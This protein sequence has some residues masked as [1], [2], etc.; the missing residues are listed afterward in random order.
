L[1][2]SV[3]VAHRELLST[4]SDKEGSEALHTRGST[5]DICLGEGECWVPVVV[6]V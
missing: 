1:D 3:T 4:A 6:W 2:S 5:S